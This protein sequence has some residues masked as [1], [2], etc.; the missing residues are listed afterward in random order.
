M[1]DAVWQEAAKHYDEQALAAL[2][3]MIGLTNLFN[4]VNVAVREPEIASWAS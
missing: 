1:P 4:R 2:V 3:L